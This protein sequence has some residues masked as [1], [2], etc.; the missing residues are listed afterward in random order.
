MSRILDRSII[1]GFFALLAFTALAHGAVE[2]WSAALWETGTAILL[3]LWGIK[4]AVDKRLHFR[5]PAAALPIGGLAALALAQSTI[6]NLS[7]D[8]E[9]SRSAA[10]ALF[11]AFSM[12]L[13]GANF[14][15]SHGRLRA[16]ANFLVVFGL[17]LAVFGLVQHFTWNGKLYWFRPNT[18]SASPFG[19]FVN[20]NHFAGLMGMLI[21]LAAALA[22]SDVGF[23]SRL[24]Y[25][26]AAAVMGVASVLS[27]SRG[28][29]ISLIAAFALIAAMTSRRKRHSHDEEYS[30]TPHR[31]RRKKSARRARVLAPA[32]FVLLI[33]VTIG[34]GV[35]WIG[36]DPV[37]NRVAKSGE[38]SQS[39][40]FFMSR[41][42]IWRDTI[43]MI[44]AN[45]IF[46]VG[47][48]AYQTAYPIYSE[49]DGS[50]VVAQA[51]ND[52]LQLVA[53]GGIVAGA[54][55]LW[56]LIVIG[57]SMLKSARAHDPLVSAV[58]IGSAG[59]I[60]AML[61]HSLIDFNLQ[62]PSN[63]L[64][65]LTLLAVQSNISLVAAKRRVRTHRHHSVVAEPEV[66]ELDAPPSAAAM[67][68][69]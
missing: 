33:F 50:L 53:D 67:S 28:G 56:F 47:I 20:H 58:A 37:I 25:G 14:L 26:F 22:A 42:W 45:P 12:Y 60:F 6:T 65:F 11:S 44:K 3:L 43:A 19:P 57:R 23:E 68:G 69:L 30:E 64:V 5:I 38:A 13:L 32:A 7:K 61:V 27:L 4:L 55:A 41:G 59:G 51:H 17:A 40:T 46:G 62:L 24:F 54:L 16:A 34:A 48:G 21:T 2:P 35:L 52:Y 8:Q 15:V 49:S 1:A 36:S 31:S 39:E 10:L 66:I 9:A 63:A 29:M 18:Q